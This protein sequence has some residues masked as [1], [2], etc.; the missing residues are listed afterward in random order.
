MRVSI[1][2]KVVLGTLAVVGVLS[3]SFGA[4]DYRRL[5]ADGEAGLLA[6]A[7]QTGNRLATSLGPALWNLDVEVVRQVV[8]AEFDQPDV[9]SVRIC[10]GEGAAAELQ[11]GKPSKVTCSLVRQGAEVVTGAPPPTADV[12][13]V[14]RPIQHENKPIGAAEVRVTQAALQQRLELQQAESRQRSLVL[15][16]CTLVGLVVLLQFVVVRRIRSVLAVLEAMARGDLSRRLPERSRDE[17]GRLSAAVNATVAALLGRSAAVEQAAQGLSQAST[18]LQQISDGLAAGAD[19]TSSQLSEI[20]TATTDV[21]QNMQAVAAASQEIGAASNDIA[22]RAEQMDVVGKQAGKLAGEVQ[23]AIHELDAASRD[24]GGVLTVIS[25][26]AFQTNLLALNAAI[27]AARAGEAGRGF[28]VVASEVKGL[29]QRT[30]ESTKTVQAR[31]SSIQQ[32][33]GQSVGG[34]RRIA[35]VVASLSSM[36]AAVRE[37]VASQKASIHHLSANGVA[38]AGAAAEMAD[39]I[40][41]LTVQARETSDSASATREA[42]LRLQAITSSLVGAGGAA[43]GSAS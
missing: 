10:E 34:I 29:S 43:P 33:V 32:Q 21:S 17:L 2:H 3:F 25:D 5:A 26:I 41:D 36:Q 24:V 15:A 42:A 31:I 7:A 38:V 12:V 40:K 20:H 11:A 27:E 30:A 18:H 14:V 9:V 16:G 6:T 19:R 22:G 35:E 23:T 1:I 13:V 4:A 37:E 8:G 39:R 28:A